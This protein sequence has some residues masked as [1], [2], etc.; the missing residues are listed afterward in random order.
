MN[1]KSVIWKSDSRIKMGFLDNTSITVDAVLTK[2]GR[3]LLARG[4]NEFQITKFALADDEVDY[5]LWDTA[6]PNGSN[7]YGS[8]IENMP[9]LEAFVDENQVMRYKLVSLPKQTAK[10]PIVEIGTSVVSLASPGVSQ[11][12]TPI[13]RNGG[14]DDE[15]G[16]T[17]ILHNAEIATLTPV[18]QSG[19]TKKSKKKFFKGVGNLGT[20]GNEELIR[21]IAMLAGQGGG[22]GAAAGAYLEQIQDSNTQA[23]LNDMSFEDGATTTVFLN[24]EEQKKSTTLT[25]KS[26]KLIARSI[27]STT[28]TNVTII[29]NGSGATVNIPVTVN[30]DPSKA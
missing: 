19:K 17:F 14:G 22:A 18:A 21:D 23:D 11:V 27:N 15:L 16:Y 13:T 28:T 9:L 20:K 25:G 3:E 8:V 29:G 10:L 24:D 1:K 5:E 6:H 4:Q 30:Q 26:I 7:Y 12:L 2:K